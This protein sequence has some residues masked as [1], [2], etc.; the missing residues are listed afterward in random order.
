TPHS[1]LPPLS[2]HHALPI[3]Y[4]SFLLLDW[5]HDPA[6]S[7]AAFPRASAA[8]FGSPTA[9]PRP[10]PFGP[11]AEHLRA[12]L[13]RGAPGI[14]GPRPRYRSEEHTSELQS[15]VNLVCR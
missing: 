14:P 7:T 15:R 12:L 5:S 10:G 2:L 9:F 6:S 13:L 4:S 1:A 3:C 11:L 8:R